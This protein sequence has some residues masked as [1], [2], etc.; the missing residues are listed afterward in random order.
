MTVKYD[1]IEAI[2]AE[3]QLAKT[4]L[5]WAKGSTPHGVNPYAL[6]MVKDAE[7]IVSLIYGE[8]RA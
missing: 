8:G 5:D 4:V 3:G 7:V 1:S 6:P 2:L